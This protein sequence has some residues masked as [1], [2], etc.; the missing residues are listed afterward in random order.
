LPSMAFPGLITVTLPRHAKAPLI[1]LQ[2][3]QDWRIS[4]QDSDDF[5]NK[6][7]EGAKSSSRLGRSMIIFSRNMHAMSKFTSFLCTYSRQLFQKR[8]RKVGYEFTM[9]ICPDS[10]V[11]EQRHLSLRSPLTVIRGQ[12][13]SPP[14]VDL[15]KRL[16][17]SF[18]LATMTTTHVTRML[19]IHYRPTLKYFTATR[20]L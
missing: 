18:R 5:G 4:V 6:F 13:A 14:L 20:T 1:L 10:R 19:E 3:L 16:R 9:F 8:R 17:T 2:R 12:S 7:Q 11:M 15:R